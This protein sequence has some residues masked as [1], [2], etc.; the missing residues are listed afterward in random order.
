ML[1]KIK[2]RAAILRNRLVAVLTAVLSL[3]PAIALALNVTIIGNVDDDLRSQLEN[4]SLL[5]ETAAAEEPADAREIVSAAQADYR[6]FLAIFYDNGYFGPSI[7]I[8]LDGREAA[9]IP[10]ISPPNAVSN[11]TITVEPGRAFRFGKTQI[12]PT[13][14]KTRLPRGFAP[15]E[16]ARVSEVQSAARA[17]VSGWRDAGHAKASVAGQK[18]TARHNKQKLDVDVTIDPGPKLRF[19]PLTVQGKSAVR[20]ERIYE[21]AALPEGE[22]FSPKELEDAAAR[23][24]RTGAFRS[25]AVIEEDVA[26]DGE[27]MPITASVVDNKPR[28]LGFGVEFATIEGLTLNAFW[29]HRNL[30]GGAE[31]LRIDGFYGGI[32]GDNGGIDYGINFRFDRPATFNADT[33]FYAKLQLDHIDDPNVRSDTA[34]LEMGAEWRRSDEQTYRLGG[35]LRYSD[36]K[37]ALN[38]TNYTTFYIPA[39]LTFDY[40]NNELD[41]RRGYYLN[42]DTAPFVA[43]SGIDN[44]IY[45][46]LDLRGY[47][48]FNLGNAR[49]TTLALRF[50]LGSLAGP[51]LEDSPSD[52]L[53]YSGGGGTVRG[54][55]Y[56]S[57]GVQVGSD[58][59]DIVGGRSFLGISTEVRFRTK[60]ALGYVGF[61][62]AGYIGRESYPGKSG[63]WHTGAGLGVRYAT[64]IG[65]IRFDIAVPTSNNK[66]ENNFHVYFG[67]GQAF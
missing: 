55:D 26:G 48:S 49:A 51:S 11:A 47:R 29:L 15:G 37:D 5:Y 19:G 6:R 42:Y 3:F 53:F 4:G 66:G 12:G 21:I 17:T 50:Q 10:A 63:E 20:R 59:D 65:P 24:R 60:G 67:I 64:P 43:L 33:G 32:G 31:R 56:Q 23:L 62:D 36:T 16:P 9:D 2:T 34:A 30:F 52:F 13:A 39:G 45:N 41:A 1:V 27:T 44:G 14:P 46:R 22:V 28:R 40:R 25:V 38:D 35:G 18:I 61:F 8:K 57:L 58:D 7:S 54:H